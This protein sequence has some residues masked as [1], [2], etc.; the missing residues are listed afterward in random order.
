MHRSQNFRS[1]YQLDFD[2]QNQAK[3]LMETYTDEAKDSYGL[4]VALQL[5]IPIVSNWQLIVTASGAFYRNSDAFLLFT[6]GAA[7]QW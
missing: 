5:G 6:A 7:Y 1:N 3:F 2:D 4:P